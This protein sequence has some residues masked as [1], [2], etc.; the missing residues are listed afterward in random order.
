[1]VRITR[2]VVIQQ[3]AAGG[4]VAMIM[5][6]DEA[7]ITLMAG[8]VTQ[9]QTSIFAGTPKTLECSGDVEITTPTQT[10][11]C[12]SSL[13]DMQ[14]RVFTMRMAKRSKEDVRIFMREGGES[15]KVMRAPK[16]LTVFM[17]TNEMRA[18]GPQRVEVFNGPIPSKRQKPPQTK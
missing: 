14:Q 15:V 2:N 10:V 1:V 12:D 6:A 3:D 16:S 4:A 5:T 17:A 11:L 18:E 9:T 7:V 8:P 13:L